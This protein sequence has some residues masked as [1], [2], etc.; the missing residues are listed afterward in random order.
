M[1]FNTDMSF[2]EP[3]V[4][5]VDLVCECPPDDTSYAPAAIDERA[6]PADRR[7]PK[8]RAERVVRT[9]STDGR[10]RRFRFGDAVDAMSA[11][12]DAPPR[13]VT[14]SIAISFAVVSRRNWPR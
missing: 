8:R 14:G 11:P 10:G 7:A 9:E 4:M 5:S 13:P 6:A 3:T 2:Q 12:N 1:T